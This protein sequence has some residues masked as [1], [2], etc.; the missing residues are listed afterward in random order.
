MNSLDLYNEAAAAGILSDDTAGELT[1]LEAEKSK[2]E[3]EIERIEGD[4]RN[5]NGKIASWRTQKVYADKGTK[6]TLSSYISAEQAKIA[7]MRVRLSAIRADLGRVKERI[8]EI[9]AYKSAA[10]YINKGVT[11]SRDYYDDLISNEDND[12]AIWYSENKNTATVEQII[13]RKT[14]GDDRKIQYQTA[15]VEDL[16][17]AYEKLAEI[18]GVNSDESIHLQEIL[19]DETVAL[20]KL[21]ESYEDIGGVVA[22]VLREKNEGYKASAE[23]INLLSELWDYTDGKDAYDHVKRAED[24]K[25]LT[26]QLTAQ[27]SVVLNTAAAYAYL[28]KQYGVSSAESRELEKQLLS[29]CVAYEKLADRINTLYSIEEYDRKD[30]EDVVFGLNDFLKNNKEFLLST[31][32][33]EEEIYALAKKVTGYDQLWDYTLNAPEDDKVLSS[34][35]IVAEVFREVLGEKFGAVP[36]SFFDGMLNIEAFKNAFSEVDGV[37]GSVGGTVDFADDIFKI[38]ETGGSAGNTYSSVYNFTASGGETIADQINQ[39]KKYD[40]MKKARGLG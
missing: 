29:E 22:E 21:K 10:Y 36:D 9:S 6:K 4:I 24:I 18:Y 5:S 25:S 2:Y 40:A 37:V 39:V 13:R 1:S 15:H 26:A 3:A 38:T 35:D 23:N 33:S 19:G 7:T 16:T 30:R 34:E 20:S 27:E 8:S 17:S 14:E 31:G 28:V 12:F 32:M 11:G